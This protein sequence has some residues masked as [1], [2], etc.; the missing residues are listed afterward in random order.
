MTHRSHGSGA[1]P[2]GNGHH[3]ATGAFHQQGDRLAIRIGS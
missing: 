1:T 3:Y 2:A